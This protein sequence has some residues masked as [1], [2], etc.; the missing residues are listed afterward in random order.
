[1]STTEILQL[2]AVSIQTLLFLGGGSALVLS[3]QNANKGL[4]EDVK[5]MQDELKGLSQVITAQAV[6][7]QR[8]TEQ[9]R[10][11]TLLEERVEDLRRG[12][13][14]VQRRDQEEG[15]VDREY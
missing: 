1:M 4:R 10:R 9:S 14:Y 11:M 3:T 8:L 7:A 5:A 6:Q 13:G 12:R 15:T 2:T